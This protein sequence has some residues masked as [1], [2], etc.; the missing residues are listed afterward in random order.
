MK[1]SGR[2]R[3]CS[4]VSASLCIYI[5][6]EVTAKQVNHHNI[7]R[8]EYI[9]FPEQL[10]DLLQPIQNSTYLLDNA[11]TPGRSLPS[12]SSNDAPPPVDT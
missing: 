2:R 11:D 1:C 9:S 7:E 12:S 6:R 8:S 4:T 5:S 3:P 10:S